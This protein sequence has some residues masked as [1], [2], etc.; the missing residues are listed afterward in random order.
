[1]TIGVPSM[2]IATKVTV[3]LLPRTR[4]GHEGSK[5]PLR[6]HQLPF[7]PSLA[8]RQVSGGKQSLP[9]KGFQCSATT[10]SY[11]R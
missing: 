3:E 10:I 9:G 6:V 2:Q 5:F 1:M 4:R 11:P 8:E 7:R